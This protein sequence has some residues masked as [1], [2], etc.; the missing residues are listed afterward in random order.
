MPLW[1]EK[2]YLQLWKNKDNLIRRMEKLQQREIADK[3]D[4]DT[5]EL[6]SLNIPVEIATQIGAGEPEAEI[7]P[8]FVEE[9]C[10]VTP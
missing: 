2:P 4:A 9:V 5:Q 7:I 3:Q 8:D 1:H 10:I 6:G